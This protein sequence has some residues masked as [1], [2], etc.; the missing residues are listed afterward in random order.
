MGS[1]NKISDEFK[2]EFKT[3]KY[4]EDAVN[5]IIKVFDGQEERKESIKHRH[6]LGKG[7]YQSKI[8]EETGLPPDD[9]SLAYRNND[10]TISTDKILKNIQQIQGQW[11]LEPS[12]SVNTSLGAVS[13]DIDMETGTGKTYVY[14][15]A[16]FELNNK[17][18]WNKFIIVVPNV[19]IREG[20]YQS[21]QTTTNHF[22]DKYG[23]KFRAFKYNSS[24]LNKIDEYSQDPNINVMIINSQAFATSLREST[25]NKDGT[26]TYKNKE[27][28]IIY[29]ERDEFRSRKPI[30]IIAANKPILILDEPQKLK[31]KVTQNALKNRFN[32]LF[33]MNFSATHVEHHNLIYSLDALDAYNQKLVKKIEVKG[34]KVRHEM[35][36]KCYIYFESILANEDKTKARIEIQINSKSGIHREMRIV[37]VNDD[38]YKVSAG[39][40]MPGIEAYKGM[41]IIEIDR[42]TK[43][44]QFKDGTILH[45]GDFNGDGTEPYKRR[46]Q[47]RETILSHLHKESKLFKKG[48]KVVS[49]F[50]IDKVSNYKQY[51]DKWQ[52]HLGEY[53]KMFEEE[54]SNII[55]SRGELFD[56]D[57]IQYL[58]K[59]PIEELHDGYF[60]I[61]KKGHISDGDCDNTSEGSMDVNAYDRILINKGD[62]LSDKD[63]IRFIFSHSA[64]SEGWDNPN[65]FQICILKH[66]IYSNSTVRRRQEVGRGMR[67]CVDK[68]GIRQDY[69]LLGSQF[70]DTNLLTV[71]ADEDYETF[72]K[73]LQDETKEEIR[74]RSRPITE[75]ILANKRVIVESGEIYL[76]PAQ[77]RIVHGYLVCNEY[78]DGGNN[79]T[80]KLKEDLKGDCLLTFPQSVQ[81]IADNIKI[82]L[83]SLVNPTTIKDLYKDGRH[84][85]IT[86]KTRNSEE[87]NKLWNEINHKY[88]YKVQYDSN[89]LIN[90]AVKHINDNLRVNSPSYTVKTGSQKYDIGYEQIVTGDGFENTFTRTEKLDISPNTNIT[91]DIIG[92]IASG[93]RLTRKTIAKILYRIDDSKFDKFKVNPEEFISNV[94]TLIK[95]KKATIV[96]NHITYEKSIDT[97]DYNIFTTNS[98]DL[99]DDV[100][101]T[102]KSIQEYIVT[103]ST[104]ERTF[105]DNLDHDESVIVYAKL[106]KGHNGYY[107]PTPVGDYSPDWAIAFK[108]NGMKHLFFVAETKGKMT[109]MILDQIEQ[110][111]IECASK[112]FEQLYKNVRYAKI[113]TFENLIDMVKE[114]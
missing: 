109:T 45:V 13:L 19:A 18:G 21:I 55:K 14:T 24:D 75:K 106:P 111:K 72:V 61:D 3:L 49:L 88:H 43:T 108:S 47:I 63:H 23:K 93:T 51:D 94:T 7:G 89:E 31:G 50:F 58:T 5:S 110:S 12:I 80:D 69:A 73:G 82:I 20:V 15:K 9:C 68:K 57:Y 78:L 22:M 87:F 102:I 1:E 44:M 40:N 83:K 56:P 113:D 17:F 101:Q 54:Y 42:S 84:L 16:I 90:H 26:V 65:V 66:T 97:F 60:S 2:F 91:Y 95:E 8:D 28:R 81:N 112:L 25:K 36:D 105:A 67:I 64:L 10:L 62:I 92:K 38:L 46:V 34:I 6:D 37:N 77:A 99:N 107:I 11:G 30:D 86:N 103:D 104:I 4:Q 41:R 79:P 27:N 85:E 32:V 98:P 96:V 59:I 114:E 39:T 33:S 71:I 53:G 100:Y 76:E 35:G 29:S 70:H 74:I 48:I 52:L